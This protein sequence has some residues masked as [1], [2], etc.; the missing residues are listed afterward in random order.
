MI[1]LSLDLE[2]VLNHLVALDNPQSLIP[3]VDKRK[4]LNPHKDLVVV[5]ILKLESTQWLSPPFVIPLCQDTRVLKD[6]SK[7]PLAQQLD[8]T[9]IRTYSKS[10]KILTDLKTF[11]FLGAA[12]DV[13]Q[14]TTL[15]GIAQSLPFHAQAS[16]LIADSYIITPSSVHTRMISQDLGVIL[17]QQADQDRHQL[18]VHHK[19][20]IDNQ[21]R[22][23]AI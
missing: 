18:I 4:D 21:G 3:E 10:L 14:R 9:M 16:A 17:D 2:I 11:S 19:K 12:L 23:I 1:H 5:L 20:R 22:Q 13:I 7:S 8:P 6:L 15:D